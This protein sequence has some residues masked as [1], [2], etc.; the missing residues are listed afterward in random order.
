MLGFGQEGSI[1]MKNK[2]AF[3]IL[4]ALMACLF[5]FVSCIVEVEEEMVESSYAELMEAVQELRGVSL[6]KIPGIK[7]KITENDGSTL[8][9]YLTGNVTTENYQQILDA[10]VSVLGKEYIEAD[11]SITWS[12]DNKTTQIIFYNDENP[13]MNINCFLN[14]DEK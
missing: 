8:S 1:Y 10:F 2:K 13:G 9:S 14:N 11:N 7:A 4:I 6:P 5:V 3:I 12:I